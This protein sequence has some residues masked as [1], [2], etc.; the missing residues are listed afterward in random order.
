MKEKAYTGI[1]IFR[2]AAAVMVIAIHTYPLASYGES[3]DYLFTH[4]LCRLAV[5]FFFTASGFF[6]FRM[7]TYDGKTVARF[8]KKTAVLYFFAIVLYI[9]VNI[10]TGYFKTKPLLPSLIRDLL[11]DGTFYHLW[12]LPAALLGAGLAWLLI[13]RIGM[14]GAIATALV[15]YVVGLFGDSY[16]GLAEKLP[17]A[18]GLYSNLFLVSGY[19]RNGIF[20]APV[21]FILGS[22]L[23]QTAFTLPVKRALPALCGSLLLLLG[24]GLL[25]RKYGLQRHDSM[26][27]MLVPCIY[28]LFCCL[29]PIRG[30]RC[31]TCAEISLFVYILHP[32]GILLVRMLGKFTDTEQFLIYNSLVHFL[33]TT[34]VS[35]GAACFV[36]RVL[37]FI[38]PPRKEPFRRMT[39]EI[40]TENLRHN[41]RA[42]QKLIQEP[43][44]IMAVVKADAY[45]H[46]APVVS[47]VLNEEGITDFAVATIEEGIALRESGIRGRILIFGYTDPQQVRQLRKYRLTQTIVS[48]EYALRL[49]QKK[50]CVD[51]HIKIDT[52]M[53]RIG[54]DAENPEAVLK[55][56]DL[57][58]LNVTGMYTH[59]CVSDSLL[60]ENVE[61]T[62]EQIAKIEQ[63]SA[64]LAANGCK[65][66]SLH[67]Q[68]T[69]GLLNY[70]YLQYDYVRP[71]IALYGVKSS[72]KTDAMMPV[73]LNP[74]LTLKSR[75]VS[76]RKIR[77][78]ES[79]G[80]GRSYIAVRD[81]MLA[82][83]PAGYADGIPRC[84][85]GTGAVLIRGKK[86]PVI[87]RICMDQMTVDIT[88]IPEA[89]VEDPVI[90]IGKD[91]TQQI[92]AEEFAENAGSITNEILCRIGSRVE[93]IYR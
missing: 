19:T 51:V 5:P 30:R 63:L 72:F 92:C 11:F 34:A 41:V 70:P 1:D 88:D 53:H 57:K 75:I 24:E 61:F 84:L 80:Y 36:V 21:F 42:L 45:G 68:N 29:K 3:A 49:N 85:S 83:I 81:S 71:G 55:L 48:K 33:L 27:F 46:G 50:V 15:L 79:V 56:F 86:A 7:G 4:V 25:L 13:K 10:Y 38:R 78:G 17:I 31:K 14:K 12:Y 91:G 82:V 69:S 20:F 16:Y 2:I 43:C 93:R 74:V 26:Y 32:L 9:P 6:L 8:L 59:L 60:E 23:R 52:G 66:P 22:A 87:G 28:F 39:A 90:L 44:K 47:S 77:Q 89:A 62:L 40:D 67:I 73:A 76:I 64:A 58:Y 35:F 18:E 65:V 54:L 37:H